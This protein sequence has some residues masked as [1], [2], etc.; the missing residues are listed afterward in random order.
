MIILNKRLQQSKTHFS[1]VRKWSLKLNKMQLNWVSRYRQRTELNW[2]KSFLLII[3]NEGFV[4]F[5]CWL[6]LT[7]A[8]HHKPLCYKAS[9]NTP[10]NLIF[11]DR[12]SIW[13]YGSPGRYYYIFQ[14]FITIL[15]FSV[16]DWFYFLHDFVWLNVLIFNLSWRGWRDGDSPDMIFSNIDLQYFIVKLESFSVSS[17]VICFLTFWISS[18]QLMTFRSHILYFF[19]E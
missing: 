15:N 12:I 7:L 6:A 2:A 19:W 10:A 16:S 18:V 1:E 13:L 14:I 5:F 3:F 11:S 17:S 4:L 8:V 9:E